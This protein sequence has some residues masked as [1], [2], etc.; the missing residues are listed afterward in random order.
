M[1]EHSCVLISQFVGVRLEL[2]H[3]H[4]FVHNTAAV[5]R[6]AWTDTASATNLLFELLFYLLLL[7]QAK[8]ASPALE[9]KLK[10]RLLYC[11]LGLVL[12][13]CISSD[14]RVCN[15]LFPT[16]HLLNRLMMALGACGWQRGRD[17]PSTREPSHHQARGREV[18]RILRVMLCVFAPC[19]LRW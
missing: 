3:H 1:P 8:R 17:S 15:D 6:C 16:T 9:R 14:Y 12:I 19:L 5:L 11:L 4:L 7:G 13:L 10:S 2:H 18:L